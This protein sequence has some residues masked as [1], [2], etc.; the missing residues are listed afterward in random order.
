M[1]TGQMTSTM[2]WAPR[3]R[4]RKQAKLARLT[5]SAC[6]ALLIGLVVSQLAIALYGV[7]QDQVS[8]LQDGLANA[9]TT[10][11]TQSHR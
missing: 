8:N 1:A 3:T 11:D 10:T 6:R 5:V 4:T 9:A 7:M 2:V